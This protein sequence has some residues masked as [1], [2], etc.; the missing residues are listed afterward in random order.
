MPLLTHCPKCRATF[1]LPDNLRGKSAQC[2]RCKQVFRVPAAPAAVPE[3]VPTVELQRPPTCQR[4]NWRPPGAGASASGPRPPRPGRAP[5]A[6]ALSGT[7]WIIALAVGVPLLLFVGLIILIA[8]VGAYYYYGVAPTPAVPPVSVVTPN[9]VPVPQAPNDPVPNPGGPVFP[10]VQPIQ[11]AIP[12]PR[13]P[14]HPL[15]PPAPV[16]VAPAVLAQDKVVKPLPS[17][18]S[19][20]VVGGGGRFLILSLP[21]QK[22]LA[23]FDVSAGEVVKYLSFPAP[24]AA[25]AAGMDQLIVAQ[26]NNLLRYSLKTFEQEQAAPVPVGGTVTAL[27]MGSASNGPLWVQVKGGPPPGGS[28]VLVDPST[29]KEWPADWG[30]KRPPADAAY[31]RASEDGRVFGMR[32][33]RRRTAHPDRRDPP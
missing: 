9:P 24:V 10:P 30:E 33:P 2:S 17:P 4:S 5:A 20:A 32:G 22:K 7:G 1:N 28:A 18:V 15:K 14:P 29:L 19:D 11:P 26:P 27:C 16:D 12:P 21:L 13:D 23:I 6:R 3:D 25:F 8:A 31:L